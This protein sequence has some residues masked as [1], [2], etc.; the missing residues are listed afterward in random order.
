LVTLLPGTAS[1]HVTLD[2]YGPELGV[3]A[4]MR[5]INPNGTVLQSKITRLFP[6]KSATLSYR[7][8]G[9]VRVQAEIF[10][11]V[12]DTTPAV[13]PVVMSSLELSLD[14]AD[15]GRYIGPIIWVP[16]DILKAIY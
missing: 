12:S 9:Q 15:V 11:S 14:G 10:Q 4:V 3:F 8:S 6:G 13:E 5:F 16:C 1:F 7:G 2:E